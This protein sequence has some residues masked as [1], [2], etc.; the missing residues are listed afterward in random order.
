MG[1]NQGVGLFHLTK[2]I[3]D[4]IPPHQ[5]FSEMDAA[6][7]GMCSDLLA[8]LEDDLVKGFYDTIFHHPPMHSV[9]Q[10][11]EREEREKTLRSWWQRTLSGPF[12]DKYWAWQAMVGMVHVKSGVKN[13]MMLTM[14]HWVSHW[15]QE[16]IIQFTGDTESSVEIME[17]FQ[18]LALTAQ[19]L[20]AESYMSNYL[21]TVQRTT[22]FKPALL[23]RMAATEIH[24]MISEAR[25]E[26]GSMA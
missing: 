14:W 23:E 4:N 10:H 2:N 19:S 20:T 9:I 3:I 5:R 22:G 12:D 21:E 1:M 6:L 25:K 13:Q 15:L 18:R 26:L 16:K 24:R 7:V 11:G 8:E 17:S